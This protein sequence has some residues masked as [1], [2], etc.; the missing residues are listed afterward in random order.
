LNRLKTQRLFYSG[1]DI[2]NRWEFLELLKCRPR[3]PFWITAVQHSFTSLQAR[4]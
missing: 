4:F 2:E 1:G 3:L